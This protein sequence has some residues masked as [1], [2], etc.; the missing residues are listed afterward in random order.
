VFVRAY[1]TARADSTAWGL[2]LASRMLGYLGE[3]ASG[4]RLFVGKF[5][6]SY[7][8]PI[9]HGY[10]ADHVAHSQDIPPDP[11]LQ[12]WSQS[13]LITASKM[14]KLARGRPCNL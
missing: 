1:Q 6:A 11:V 14:R 12:A 4:R 2:H 3:G 13:G 8:F 7:G 10:P 5:L 9:W